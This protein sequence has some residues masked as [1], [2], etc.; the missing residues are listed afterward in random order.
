IH[1]PDIYPLSLHDALPIYGQPVVAIITCYNGP[2]EVGEKVLQPLR[3][4]GSPL[5]DQ[6]TSMTYVQ[7]QTMLDAGFPSGLQNYWKTNFLRSEEHTSELQSR[8]NLVCR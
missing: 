3:T 6:I 5:A 8:E 1:D 4:F 2:T 7:L